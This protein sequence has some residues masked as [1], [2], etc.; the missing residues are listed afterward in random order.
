MMK[1]FAFTWLLCGGIPDFSDALVQPNL[2]GNLKKVNLNLFNP[3][4]GRPDDGSDLAGP[5]VFLTAVTAAV[6]AFTP[7]Q[8]LAYT[9][10]DTVAVEDR[11]TEFDN[12]V[13]LLKNRKQPQI[14]DFD[15]SKFK[16]EIK[17]PDEDPDIED[18]IEL[19]FDENGKVCI[20]FI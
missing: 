12:A 6:I 17:I 4:H 18:D 13:K 5:R 9:T 7:I 15:R 20:R 1:S 11:S 2:K 3:K 10:D 14:L 8:V 16:I 19:Q